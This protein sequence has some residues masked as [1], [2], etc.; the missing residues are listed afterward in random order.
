MSAFTHSQ[1]R[2]LPALRRLCP[3][4]EAE[5]SPELAGST[6]VADRDPLRIETVWGAMELPVRVVVGMNPVT[7]SIPHGWAGPHNA[8]RLL[9]LA[10]RDPI[11]ATPAYKAVPCRVARDEGSTA[12]P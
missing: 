5:I 10:N 2:N 6:G 3:E 8:N 7:V 11:S 12:A 9:G 1:H 4:P